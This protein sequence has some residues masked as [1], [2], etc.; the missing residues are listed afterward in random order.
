MNGKRYMVGFGGPKGD[1]Q[2][3]ATDSEPF[4]ISR[5][6]KIAEVLAPHGYGTILDRMKGIGWAFSSQGGK[7]MKRGTRLQGSQMGGVPISIALRP[8]YVVALVFSGGAIPLC[9]TRKPLT[10]VRVAR[11]VASGIAGSTA[12]AAILDRLDRRN[13][14]TF[15]PDKLGHIK[16]AGPTHSQIGDETPSETPPAINLALARAPETTSYLPEQKKEEKLT[17][18]KQLREGLTAGGGRAGGGGRFLR[19]AV[20][21]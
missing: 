5:A 9:S 14:W 6:R 20:R 10:A 8:R 11:S 2:L 7:I 13:V 21:F 3:G 15:T 4:A 1:V 19:Y 18:P 16:V 17:P 12:H